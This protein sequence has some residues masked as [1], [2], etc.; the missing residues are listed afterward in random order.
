MSETVAPHGRPSQVLAGET[1]SPVCLSHCLTLL[2]GYPMH[3]GDPHARR[4]S[5]WRATAPQ[6]IQ[7]RPRRCESAS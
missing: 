5:D 3:R 2:V 6:Q 7:Q 4:F 1:S